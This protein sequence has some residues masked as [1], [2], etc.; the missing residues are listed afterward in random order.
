M[1]K[2]YSANFGTTGTYGSGETKLYGPKQIAIND[3]NLYIADYSNNRIV[4]LNKADMTYITAYGTTGSGN[5]NFSGIWGIA[6]DDNYIYTS[7][8]LNYRI[9]K[10]NISDFSFVTSIGSYGTGDTQFYEPHEISIDENYIYVADYRNNR[11]KKHLKSDLNFVSKIGSSGTGNDNFMLPTGIRYKDENTLFVTE[12]SINNRI[13]V[14]N[15]SDLSF[16]SMIDLSPFNNDGLYLPYGIDIDDNYLYV[17]DYGH[18]RIIKKN[19]SDLSLVASLGGP[20]LGSGNNSF[21]QPFD[22][23][24]DDDYIYVTDWT[25]NQ[26]KQYN[27]SDLSW[28]YNYAPGTGTLRYP[29]S[30]AVDGNDVYIIEKD[31]HRIKKFD[32][33]NTPWTLVATI[34]GTSAG[35]GNDEFSSPRGITIYGDYIYVADTGNHRIHKRNKSDLNYVEIFGVGVAGVGASDLFNSPYAVYVHNDIIY[36]ANNPTSNDKITVLDL[37][38][39]F[40]YKFGNTYWGQDQFSSVTD[41]AVDDNYIY[42]P[43]YIFSR[44]GKRSLT[45][46]ENIRN[47]PKT[48]YTGIKTRI[49]SIIA[50]TGT[51]SGDS[52][53]AIKRSGNNFCIYINGI[54]DVC[55]NIDYN[56]PTYLTFPEINNRYG[57]SATSTTHYLSENQN[58]YPWGIGSYGL[59]TPGSGHIKYLRVFDTNLSDSDINAL[60]QSYKWN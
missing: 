12:N 47:I 9:K 29:F 51:V 4:V 45:E 52:Q 44:I 49:A 25:Y 7:E 26:I 60:Y 39:N 1:V 5:D 6:V 46:L 13:H 56:I 54:Q 32:K 38:F 8:L 48:N 55:E 14:R 22:L 28:V 20:L 18:H 11:I 31:Y 21:N 16:N 23:A 15:P 33:S 30:I 37:N 43:D 42:M 57:S 53:I 41:L 40:L 59:T 17:A 2:G 27:K 50:S 10:L 3:S 58:Y 34:G 24:V 19:K 35:S 36:V